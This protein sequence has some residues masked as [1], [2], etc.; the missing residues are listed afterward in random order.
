M[1]KISHFSPLRSGPTE[2]FF[3]VYFSSSSF[4]S[5]MFCCS[6]VS[7]VVVAFVVS[8]FFED[9]EKKNNFLNFLTKLCPCSFGNYLRDDFQ[10]F[11]YVNY[12]ILCV[13]FI[14]IQILYY[15]SFH[16]CI[17]FS[18]CCSCFSSCCSWCWNRC[19]NC[20]KSKK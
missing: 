16:C 11:W 4:S 17:I 18:S 12:A 14:W 1:G 10:L 7:V 13:L 15:C 19:N 3:A 20:W 2:F 5:P 6:L 8:F 9:I